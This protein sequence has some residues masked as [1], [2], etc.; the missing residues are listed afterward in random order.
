MTLTTAAKVR[1][2]P[3]QGLVIVSCSKEKLVT[4]APIP[5]L[6]LYQGA[7]VPSLRANLRP[8][9][10]S[11]IR[12]LSADRGLLRPEDPVGTYDRELRSRSEAEALHGR[13]AA[14]LTADLGAPALRHVLVVLE[15]LYLTAAKCLF[16]YAPP[17]GLTLLPDPIDWPSAKAVLS[18]W[19][20]L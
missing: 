18:R 15:P 11:R 20:W 4:T 9:F 19:G 3:E 1:L 5:A 2:A 16:D 8:R 6:D 12:I 7:L 13:V 10:R 17:L 14:R